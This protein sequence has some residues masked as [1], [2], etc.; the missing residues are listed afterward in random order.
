MTSQHLRIT[1]SPIDTLLS[2][3]YTPSRLSTLTEQRYSSAV[4]GVDED[5]G[6]MQENR[7]DTFT[8]PRHIRQR[9][10]SVRSVVGRAVERRRTE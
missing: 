6:I 9:R 4:D 2:V 3:L 5:F 8:L 10:R 1:T 7:L